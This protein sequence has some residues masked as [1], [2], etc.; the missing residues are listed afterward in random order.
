MIHQWIRRAKKQQNLIKVFPKLGVRAKLNAT[1]RS[2]KVHSDRSLC[3]LFRAVISLR[4]IYLQVESQASTWK[5]LFGTR[6]RSYMLENW[7]N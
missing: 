1:L 5:S 2:P 4:T 6:A 7:M 3:A